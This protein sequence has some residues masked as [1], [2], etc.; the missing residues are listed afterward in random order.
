MPWKTILVGSLVVIG[1]ALLIIDR[2]NFQTSNKPS[3]EIAAKDISTDCAQADKEQCYKAGFGNLIKQY[4]FS[5]AQATLLAL[6]D[7]DPFT[8]SCHVLAH[9]MARDAVR[10][11][12]KN[13]LQ[14]MDSVDVNA[15]GSGFLHGVLEAHLGDDSTTKFD[16]KLSETVCDHGPDDYRRRMC[17]HFMG[18]FF[19]V[20]SQDILSQALPNCDGVADKLKFDCLDG[21]FMEHNQRIAL[22]DHGLLPAPTYTPEYAKQL[23]QGC[24]SY[25]GVQGL[26]CW[27]EMAEVYAKTFGYD[28][29]KIYDNCEHAKDFEQAESCYFKGVVI[30]A[31]YPLELNKQ[32]LVEICSFYKD[33]AT[34]QSCLTYFISSLMHYSVKFTDRGI[35]LCQNIS[36][37]NQWCFE[38][39]GRQLAQSAPSAEQRTEL[40]QTAEPKYRN[41][42]IHADVK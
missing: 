15:C 38:E 22:V 32:Q 25:N 27:T 24:S 5:F 11:S 3:V 19:V 17:T 34:Y 29:K 14:L 26:A 33:E 13:W 37:Y 42:C 6:Q 28:A 20:G 9:S 31:T 10:K 39:L 41:S 30:L 12:P 36:S 35:E 21:L 23:E 4:N 2:F 1:I 40:C 16:S 18:H 8:K 7:I